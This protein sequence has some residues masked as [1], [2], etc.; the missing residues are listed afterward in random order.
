MSRCVLCVCVCVVGGGDDERSVCDD[1]HATSAVQACKERRGIEKITGSSKASN[2]VENRAARGV[3]LH[4]E[5]A[6]R[7]TRKQKRMQPEEG[8]SLLKRRPHRAPRRGPAPRLLPQ[9]GL[10]VCVRFRP[11]SLQYSTGPRDGSYDEYKAVTSG[12]KVP[13][14][15]RA[16]RVLKW[17]S[18][19]QHPPLGRPPAH[20]HFIPAPSITHCS[21]THNTLGRL[22]ALARGSR[23]VQ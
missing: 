15:Q 12:N 20:A 7:A 8:P 16:T 22:R 17:Y 18:E 1:R 4:R 23:D 10:V 11:P 9:R 14:L 2:A 13:T 3:G 21:S 5:R 6:R 19:I